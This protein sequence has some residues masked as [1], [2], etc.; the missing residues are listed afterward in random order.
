MSCPANPPAPAGY[1]VWKGPVPSALSSWAVQLL[2]TVNKYAYGQTWT[3]DYAGQEIIARKDYH[4]WHYQPDGTLLTNICWPGIT[5]YKPLAI[6]DQLAGSVVENIE[7]TAPDPTL[8]VYDQPPR[9][10]DWGLVAL[11]GGAIVIVVASVLV[12]LHFAGRP[13]LR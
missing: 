8:A 5:L 7:T 6:T 13:G 9:S 10:T 1:D 12:G 4:V 3:L 11:S 2:K